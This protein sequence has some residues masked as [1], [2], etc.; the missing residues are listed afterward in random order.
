MN[1]TLFNRLYWI[2]RF[3]K[4]RNVKGYLV[5]DYKDFGASLHI[6]VSGTDQMQPNP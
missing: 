4:Q 2:R 6:H 3:G 1:I 5:S